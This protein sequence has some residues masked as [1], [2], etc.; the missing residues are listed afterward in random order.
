MVRVVVRFIKVHF[1]VV[2]MRES[3]ERTPGI[4]SNVFCGYC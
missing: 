4:R 2:G 3:K 1:G